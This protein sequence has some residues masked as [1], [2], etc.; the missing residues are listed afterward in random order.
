MMNE[1]EIFLD[2]P[3]KNKVRKSSATLFDHF[4]KR[5]EKSIEVG[6]V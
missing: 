6:G 1:K 2:K 4:P 5:E 3:S